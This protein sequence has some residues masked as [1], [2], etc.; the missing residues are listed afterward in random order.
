M[1]HDQRRRG[2]DRYDVYGTLIDTNYLHVAAW[3]EHPVDAGSQQT[4]GPR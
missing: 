4:H 1:A 2:G 3:W